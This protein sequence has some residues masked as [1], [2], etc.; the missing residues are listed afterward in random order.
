MSGLR[1]CQYLNLGRRK[2]S[3]SFCCWLVR[4]SS[5]VTHSK[6]DFK[7]RSRLWWTL[8]NNAS[9]C[10]VVCLFILQTG[11]DIGGPIVPS[12]AICFTSAEIHI[13]LTLRADCIVCLSALRLLRDVKCRLPN[14]VSILSAKD[15]ATCLLRPSLKKKNQEVAKE[16][17]F[18]DQGFIL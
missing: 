12:A 14:R 15:S 8:W 2:K 16:G 5:A 17:W 13:H 9:V 11:D 6:P 18:F 3:Y 7:Q 10:L 1:D 4:T